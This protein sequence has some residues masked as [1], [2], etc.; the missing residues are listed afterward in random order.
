MNPTTIR[1]LIV[2]DELLARKNLRAMLETE[3]P[4]VIVCGEADG[5][6][7]GAE[8]IR[9]LDPDLVFM[10]IRMPSASEGLDLV[11]SL[12]DPR[13]VIIFVTAFKDFAIEAFKAHALDYILKPIDPEDLDRAIDQ[14]VK[15]LGEMAASQDR[16]EAY[17]SSLG[18]TLRDSLLPEGRIVVDHARGFKIFKV[19]Q[20]VHLQAEGNCTM[21]HL[22]DGTRYLDTRTLAVYEDLLDDGAFVR[23]H[24]S[25]LINRHHLCEY[26]REDGHFA[27]MQDGSR[28]P[29]ARNR[30][31]HFLDQ[32]R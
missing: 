32:V 14:A 18:R 13:C 28:L 22:Q 10:D 11:A 8:Q 7:S 27:V 2:D 5:P 9:D 20:L 15:R 30:L 16:R 26:V 29:I 24:R 1:A 4:E 3:H 31:D 17:R 23:I 25:H 19:D 21:L 12:E 6:L